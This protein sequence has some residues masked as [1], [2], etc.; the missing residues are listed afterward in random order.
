MLPTQLTALQL[1]HD[2]QRI[3]AVHCYAGIIEHFALLY[4]E[5]CEESSADCDDDLPPLIDAEPSS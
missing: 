5:A 3:G 2:I 1:Q 4:T